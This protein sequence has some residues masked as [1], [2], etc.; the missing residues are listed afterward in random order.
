MVCC[1]PPAKKKKK[2]EGISLEKINLVAPTQFSKALVM[3]LVEKLT[4]S[5]IGILSVLN[6]RY[7]Q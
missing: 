2:K 4:C 3:L 1:S 7:I 5:I 6:L